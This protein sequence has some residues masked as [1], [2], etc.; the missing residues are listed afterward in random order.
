MPS[1]NEMTREEI[2]AWIKEIGQKARAKMEAREQQGGPLL[3]IFDDLSFA[4]GL[5]QDAIEAYLEDRGLPRG[6][7]EMIIIH[8]FVEDN[9][10]LYIVQVPKINAELFL[11]DAQCDGEFKVY[12]AWTLNGGCFPPNSCSCCVGLAAQGALWK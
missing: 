12:S 5:M 2:R 4:A 11:K 9:G 1:L 7:D 6:I 8:S 3:G 10:L